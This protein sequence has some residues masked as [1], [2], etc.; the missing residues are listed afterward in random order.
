[1]FKRRRRNL[2]Q[3]NKKGAQMWTRLFIFFLIIGLLSLIYIIL[4]SDLF[5]VKALEINLE[6]VSC[7]DSLGIRNSTDLL[8]KRMF[9]VNTNILPD[10]QRKY[11]CIKSVK[12]TKLLPNK[13]RLDISGREAVA[14]IK[15]LKPDEAS[16]SAKLDTDP[17][18]ATQ[19][20]I[21]T[22]SSLLDFS[23]LNSE[24]AFVVD[25]DGVFFDS[26]KQ[27]FGPD[28]PKNFNV[29]I[30][31]YYGE[32]IKLG[33]KLQEGSVKNAVSILS[34]VKVFGIEIKDAK[35]TGSDM[36]TDSTPKLLFSLKAD[37]DYELASLQLILEK[38]KMEDREIEFVDLR[39]SKPIVKYKAKK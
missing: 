38:A 3:A 8:G 34:K 12:V 33:Q 18:V 39:F 35:I 6:K 30:L 15:I 23:N 31:Y 37:T 28:G 25:E 1:M 10:L 24:K 16:A 27:S 36:I 4:G 2:N 7:T 32:N 11:Y 20:P 14:L 26:D 19:T 21:A 5:K 17:M 13:L 9:S 22:N 29:P